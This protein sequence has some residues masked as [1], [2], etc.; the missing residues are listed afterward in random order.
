MIANNKVITIDVIIPVYNC[1]KYI[2]R[3]ITSVISQT[4]LPNKVIIV[5]DGSTD[6]TA[7]LVKSL[8]SQIEVKYVRKN[9]GGPNS[10]RNVGISHCTSEYIAFL[11]SDD[12]WHDNKLAEQVK[13]LRNTAFDNL[14]VV[15]CK[16]VIIDEDGETLLSLPLDYTLRGRIYDRLFDVNRIVSSASGV[17]VK[18]EC[19][20]KTGLFDESLRAG[21]DWDMWLRLAKHYEFDYVGKEVVKIR[22]HKNNTQNNKLYIFE[23]MLN[24]YNKWV[25]F[26]PAFDNASKEWRKDILR[27]IVLALPNIKPIY[28]VNNNMSTEAKQTIFPLCNGSILIYILL[29]SPIIIIHICT[30]LLYRLCVILRIK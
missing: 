14:G 21:E 3:A 12:E 9:N 4:Y 24:F 22:R 2:S 19:F 15:Y 30:T 16:S 25:M 11:D 20:S 13:T 6:G 29:L 17:L 28:L 23:N 8:K 18:R 26:I 10:A 7:D 1:E 5:D 27:Q